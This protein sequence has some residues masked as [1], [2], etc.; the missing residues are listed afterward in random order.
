MSLTCLPGNRHNLSR[1]QQRTWVL[2][3]GVMIANSA[4]CLISPGL[5]VSIAQ[6]DRKLNANLLYY[7][8]YFYCCCCYNINNNNNCCCSCSCCCC[9]YYYYY[10]Y[11]YYLLNWLFLL[12]SHV[13]SLFYHLL[14]QFFFLIWPIY[15]EAD[16]KMKANLPAR[17]PWFSDRA[18]PIVWQNLW[19][20]KV[21]IWQ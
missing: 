4:N 12:S 14:L 3:V 17:G 8:V 20:I 18:F 21:K 13:C 2:Y 10:Y 1:M 11:Y 5:L 9:Y 6:G 15:M 7:Y 19:F 16:M